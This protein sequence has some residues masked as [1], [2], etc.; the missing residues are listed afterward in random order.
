MDGDLLGHAIGCAANGA[1]HV[2]AVAVTVDII[3][4]AADRREPRA[5]AAG[6]LGVCDEDT[7]ID[8]VGVDACAGVGIGVGRIERQAGLVDAVEPPSGACLS[9][10]GFEHVGHAVGFNVV[11]LRVALKRGRRRDLLAGRHAHGEPVQGG[12]VNIE[13]FAVDAGGQ[14]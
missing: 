8:D 5:D 10:V 4:A 12:V 14:A 9:S 6:E 3:L 7:R 2:R 13:N 11:D 1:R